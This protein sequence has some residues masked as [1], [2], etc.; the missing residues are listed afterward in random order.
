MKPSDEAQL[1]DVIGELF[2]DRTAVRF[3]KYLDG[4][5]LVGEDG[6]LILGWQIVTDK[7]DVGALCHELC[8]FVEIDEPRM[9]SEGWGFKYPNPQYMPGSYGG[10]S[11]F[12]PKTMSITARELR[13]LA[14]QHHVH[15]HFGMHTWRD[16]VPK[17][18]RW[19]PDNYNVP[20]SGNNH[21]GSRAR[22]IIAHYDRLVA[23]RRYT[24]DRF[25]S[26]WWR[27]NDILSRRPKYR[28]AKKAT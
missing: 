10:S 11:W 24:Y 22:W 1:H 26:E 16:D 3:D 28:A 6:V 19:L 14:F 23:S 13:V 8:H 18:M 12:E 15:D 7:F 17:L 4:V 25:V 9:S 20:G 5:Q 21:D 2:T 27:R